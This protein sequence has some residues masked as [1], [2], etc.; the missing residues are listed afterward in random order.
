MDSLSFINWTSIWDGFV[1]ITLIV[2]IGVVVFL[3][4]RSVWRFIYGPRKELYKLRDLHV[5]NVQ[6]IDLLQ[7]SVDMLTAAR[8]KLVEERDEARRNH[9]AQRKETDRNVRARCEAQGDARE[10]KQNLAQAAEHHDR[11][12]SAAI[13]LCDAVIDGFGIRSFQPV[14]TTHDHVLALVPRVRREIKAL[15]SRIPAVTIDEERDHLMSE[16]VAL[17]RRVKHLSE[18]NAAHPPILSAAI[19]TLRRLAAHNLFESRVGVARKF[20]RDAKTAWG[21][22]LFNDDPFKLENR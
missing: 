4:S 21:Y 11:W 9:Q 19:R 3:V 12:R 22:D 18:A 13:A 14:T 7:H 5:E 6:R 10:A 17:R 8:D 1:S 16:N 20:F 2:W 15:K